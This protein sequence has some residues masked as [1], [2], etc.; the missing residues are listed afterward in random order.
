MNTA[1]ISQEVNNGTQAPMPGAIKQAFAQ[2]REDD[3]KLIAKLSARV[4]ELETVLA[5]AEPEPEK[6]PVSDAEL[7][8]A[9]AKLE[10][11]A[12][13]DL[14]SGNPRATPALSL[15][16]VFGF[17]PVLTKDQKRELKQVKSALAKAYSDFH[18]T[19]LAEAKA[20]FSE[21]SRNPSA[22]VSTVIRKRKDSTVSRASLAVSEPA[23][24]KAK[25][26]TGKPKV[27]PKGLPKAGN[28]SQPAVVS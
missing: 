16:K 19:R 23:K 22:L 26:E 20:L 8:E 7:L 5:S 18:R 27:S 1:E 21:V 15:L 17:I 25:K 2:A 14:A 13:A 11:E 4:Q 10:T 24:A 12:K 9:F 28:A 3:E 6:K